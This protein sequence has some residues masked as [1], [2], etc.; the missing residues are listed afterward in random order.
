MTYF[1]SKENTQSYILLNKALYGDESKS[2]I[3]RLL[4]EGTVSL[5]KFYHD[6]SLGVLLAR[7]IIHAMFIV[8]K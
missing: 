7:L 4:S 8:K 5:K 3:G 1:F 6:Y 2:K